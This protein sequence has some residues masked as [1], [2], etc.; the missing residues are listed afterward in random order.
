SFSGAA[1]TAPSAANNTTANINV[2]VGTTTGPVSVTVNGK[3]SDTT[4]FTVGQLLTD[5]VIASVYKQGTTNAFGYVYDNIEING[6]NFGA[7]PGDGN[8]DTATNKVTIAG[9]TIPDGVNV[10]GQDPNG[11]AVYAWSDTQIVLGIPSQEGGTYL[12]AGDLSVV[13]TAGGIQTNS[14]SFE[15]RPMV[16]G[17]NPDNG[18]VGTDVSIEGTAFGTN[19]ANISVSFNGTLATPST[20]NDTNLHVTVPAGTTTGALSITVNGQV[21][22]TNITFQVLAAAISGISPDPALIGQTITI[23]GND[24]GGAQGTGTLTIGGVTAT[25]TFWNNTQIIAAVPTGVGSGS[26]VVSVS[27]PNGTASADLTISAA[28]TDSVMIDDFEGG[29]VS[30]WIQ[31]PNSGYYAYG[32]N[33]TPDNNSINAQLRTTEAVHDGQYGAKVKYSYSAATA[34]GWGAV[35][36]NPKSLPNPGLVSFN[37]KWDGSAN[38]LEVS[39]KDADGTIV[40]STI[41]NWTLAAI[42]GYGQIQLHTGSFRETTAGTVA[43]FNWSNVVNYNFNYLGTGATANFQSIDSL[44]AAPT[45]TTAGRNYTIQYSSE[46]LSENWLAVPYANAT[47]SGGFFLGNSDGLANSI[48]SVII[49]Q[50]ND[51]LTIIGRDNSGQITVGPIQYMYLSGVWDSAGQTPIALRLGYMYIVTISNPGRPTI[52]VAWNVDG[53]VGGVSLLF[54]YQS[55]TL[56]EN[57]LSIPMIGVAVNNTDDFAASLGAKIAPLDNDLLTFIARDNQSQSL[58]GPIQYRYIAASGTWDGGGQPP[59]SILAGDTWKVTLSN[60]GRPAVNATW[61]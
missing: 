39:F 33:L 52:S 18:P 38:S 7:D 30:D 19:P 34:T 43:G 42:S 40:A 5:P 27:T 57:W 49:P 46:I 8:R 22:N 31:N 14:Q 60:P 32:S 61:P 12:V 50:P 37:I 59:F 48:G 56:A 1:P 51:L 36:V 2:P 3:A 41:P 9:L 20:V 28:P 44:S 29:A 54:A 17:V 11:V 35:L 53:T 26:M 47:G 15:L 16:Y 13:V 21:S 45:V 10:G 4:S 6:T 55:E 24:F 23:S 58:V 25:P